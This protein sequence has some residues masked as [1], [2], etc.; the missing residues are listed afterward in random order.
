MTRWLWYCF[1]LVWTGTLLYNCIFP[2]LRYLAITFFTYIDQ[3]LQSTTARLSFS[4][5]D[6]GLDD[7][8]WK[9]NV[10]VRFQ[11]CD[12][13]W[14]LLYAMVSSSAHAWWVGG[15]SNRYCGH[16]DLSRSRREYT[17]LSKLLWYAETNPRITTTP[18]VCVH[19]G[20]SKVI[21]YQYVIRLFT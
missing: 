19:T 11:F 3:N 9:Y 7:A 15:Y 8:G 4:N 17:Y 5:S 12:S 2:S 1:T 6:S 10:T 20:L 13:R 16:I 14:V 18:D 21:H